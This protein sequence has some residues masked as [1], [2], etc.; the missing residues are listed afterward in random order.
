L[1]AAVLVLPSLSAEDKAKDEGKLD[2]AK[3]LG[4]WNFVSGERNGQK[5]PE[6]HFTKVHID[7][8][9]DLIYLKSDDATYEI[10][11]SLDAKKSPAAISLEIVKGPQGMGAKAE[12][13]IAVKGDEMKICYPAM[14]GDAPK[15]FSAKD[16][17][18]LHLFVLKKK[19]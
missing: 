5:V 2:Q 8:T 12:A 3:L 15:E 6:D 10:K 9:K 14:G 17:S 16:G 13:I 4:V 18:N 7:I 19:K 11:Y 1:G